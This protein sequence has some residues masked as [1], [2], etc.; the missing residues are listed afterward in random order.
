MIQKANITT[1]AL[2]VHKDCLTAGGES[3]IG[4]WTTA[5]LRQGR[6]LNSKPGSGND[7]AE[8]SGGAWVQV[9]RLGNPLVNEVV[10]GL[11]D[12]DKFNASS[13]KDDGQFLT[14]V[15][16]PTFPALLNVV[17]GAPVAP[18]NLPRTDLLT[19]FLTGITGVNK[20]ATPTPSEM[21]RLNT[22]V[23][24]VPFANQNRLGV[25][26]NAL[27]GGTDNAGYPNGRRP[28]D[29]VVDISLVAM[30]GGLCAINGA[31][32]ALKLNSVPGVPS[33]T[34]KC[35]ATALTS[36]MATAGTNGLPN[37]ANIHD[38]VDQATV[39]FL[40]TFPYLNN[41]NAGAQ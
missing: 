41:P 24:A 38:A 28:K 6:L 34:S 7:K 8:K 32:D 26:G 18:T 22:A 37:A 27:A 29:D 5:S 16:N 17:L 21:M 20:P 30:V 15:S 25:A 23:A 12:K 3:V 2:E 40:A 31:G 13:P 19:T 35:D 36:L 1:L 10:I 11:P 39:P 14:Y 9:S 33:L 4:G